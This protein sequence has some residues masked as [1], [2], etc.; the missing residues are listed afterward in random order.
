MFLSR[1]ICYKFF[2]FFCFSKVAFKMDRAIMVKSIVLD[3]PRNW[4]R[5]LSFRQWK[6][7]T[8][9]G[10]IV[11]FPSGYVEL[12]K[13]YGI[14]NWKKEAGIKLPHWKIGCPPQKMLVGGVSI[15]K[16]QVI[17]WYISL[18]SVHCSK[19]LSMLFLET[20][21][22]IPSNCPTGRLGALHRKCWK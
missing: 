22:T 14:R 19:W 13:N 11:K 2:L 5:K 17:S 6:E 8:N 12:Q 16:W 20:S 10:E 1:L 4:P 9:S 7:L 18:H 15:S 21:L 3:L